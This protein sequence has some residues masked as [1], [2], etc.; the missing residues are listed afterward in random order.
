MTQTVMA[1]V[2]VTFT[3]PCKS[4]WNRKTTMDQII[5][6]AKEEVTNRMHRLFMSGQV[7]VGPDNV[8]VHEQAPGPLHGGK[9]LE[10]KVQ[11]VSVGPT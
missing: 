6:Q 9:I 5:E 4:T 11:A 1:N 7:S 8:P 10:L 2:T 3:V